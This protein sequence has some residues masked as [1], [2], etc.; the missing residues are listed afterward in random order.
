MVVRSL[1]KEWLWLCMG[2]KSELRLEGCPQQEGNKVDGKK[3]G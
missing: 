2:A 3:H 1:N